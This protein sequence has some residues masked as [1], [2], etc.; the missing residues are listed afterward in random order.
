[1]LS[2]DYKNIL[3]MFISKEMFFSKYALQV[4]KRNYT[5]LSTRVS[6]GKLSCMLQTTKVFKHRSLAERLFF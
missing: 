5:K 3:E 1:M 4:T 6:S 2:Y